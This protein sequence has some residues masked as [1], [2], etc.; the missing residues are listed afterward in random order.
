MK[1]DLQRTAEAKFKDKRSY[2]SREGHL[3]VRG[4]DVGPVRDWIYERDAGWCKLQLSRDCRNYRGSSIP[5]DEF[6]LHHI[7]GGLG[8]KRCWCEH[9]LQVACRACHR[10]AHVAPRWTPR[11]NAR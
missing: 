7:V 8:L 2:W 3:Y 6:E 5:K 10:A 9:N 11:G 4:E 1:K